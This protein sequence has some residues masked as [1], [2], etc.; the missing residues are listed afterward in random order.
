M[1]RTTHR[2][3]GEF[4][5]IVDTFPHIAQFAS[6]DDLRAAAGD[7]PAGMWLDVYRDDAVRAVRLSPAA[8]GAEDGEVSR[9]VDAA[10]FTLTATR[11]ALDVQTVANI[12]KYALRQRHQALAP[13]PVA[14]PVPAAPATA[15]A[16]PAPPVTARPAPSPRPLGQVVL[17]CDLT[18]DRG[19]IIAREGEYADVLAWPWIGAVTVRITNRYGQSI[20]IDVSRRHLARVRR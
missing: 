4:S 19:R 2:L 10:V 7:G 13:A 16:P 11:V 5:T 12:A 9:F 18:D 15:V 20:T 3:D 17:Q 8:A 14:A 1:T 6:M